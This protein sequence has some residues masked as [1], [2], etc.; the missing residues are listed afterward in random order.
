[1]RQS[2][3]GE[4]TL[5]ALNETEYVVLNEAERLLAF[6]S[7]GAKV[8]WRLWGPLGEPMVQAV[9]AGAKAQRDYLRWMRQLYGAK[10][11]TELQAGSYAPSDQRNS[12]LDS[13]FSSSRNRLPS[14]SSSTVLVGEV[15]AVNPRGQHSPLVS[16]RM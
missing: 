10:S 6:F 5:R 2:P 16:I 7:E 13:P 9:E 12:P 8:Y 11:Y 14:Q 15:G 4:T 1:M 3:N